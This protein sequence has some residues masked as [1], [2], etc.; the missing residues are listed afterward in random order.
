MERL[1]HSYYWPGLKRDVQVQL[2][3]CPTCD[4]FHRPSK[5]LRAKLN[6]IQTNDR[7]DILAIDVFG[8]KA[9]L[10]ETPRGNRYILTM[11]DLFT[12]FCIAAA[13]PHQSAQPVADPLLER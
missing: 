12:K 10:P 3:T 4:K 11:V 9:S 8:G 2:A 1:V 5:R 7:G 13:M 6:P